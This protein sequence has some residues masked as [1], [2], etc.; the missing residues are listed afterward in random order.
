MGYGL[1]LVTAPTA[2]PLTVG[3]AKKH[4]ELAESDTTHDAT[5]AALLKAARQCV[6]NRTNRQLVTATWDLKLDAF[7]LSGPILLPYAPV[8]SVTSIT[9]V[10]S[11]GDSQT[12]ASS[13]YVVSTSREPCEVRL[14]YSKSF[15]VTR[16]QPDA[17]TV[18]FVAGYGDPEDVP[19]AIKQAMLLL[20]GHWFENREAVVTGTIATELPQSAEALLTQY[21]YG[22]EFTDYA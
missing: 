8:A 14:A 21:L 4:V 15:P 16:V 20:L 6:E 10:D 7:P 22:D 17:V 13:N 1:T 9:Y 19:A 18:R 12:W 3:E 2:E 11:A 5:L